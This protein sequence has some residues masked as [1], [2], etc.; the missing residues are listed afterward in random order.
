[1]R[2]TIHRAED[3]DLEVAIRERGEALWHDIEESEYS[4]EG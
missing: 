2:A 1:M 4:R 3:P